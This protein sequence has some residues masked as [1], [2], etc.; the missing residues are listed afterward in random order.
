MLKKWKVKV[1]L[2]AEFEIYAENFDD[3]LSTAEA[4]PWIEN[5]TYVNIDIQEKVDEQE[6]DT[7]AKD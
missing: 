6:P 2:D 4:E 1:E 3:A 7:T 5:C